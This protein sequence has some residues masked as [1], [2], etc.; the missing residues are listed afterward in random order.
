MNRAFST[1]DAEIIKAYSSSECGTCQT[2][3]K[4][5]IASQHDGHYLRG[6]SFV[7]SAIAV[8]PLQALGAIVEVNGRTPARTVVDVTGATVETLNDD[9]AF[10][11]QVAVKWLQLRWVVSGIRLAT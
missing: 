7:I 9:G 11:F 3:A 10:H 5:L 6:D 8:P 4:A 2:Y 1:S